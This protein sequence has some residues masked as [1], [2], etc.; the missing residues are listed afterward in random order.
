M[1]RNSDVGGCLTF[2]LLHEGRECRPQY[3]YLNM[4]PP[5]SVSPVHITTVRQH[6]PQSPK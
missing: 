1:R 2:L 4:L 6:P 3:G 5:E